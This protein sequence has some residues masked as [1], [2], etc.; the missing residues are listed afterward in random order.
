MANHRLL[1]REVGRRMDLY[2]RCRWPDLPS[3]ADRALRSA[4]RHTLERFEPD[5]II[6]A[7]THI[8]GN[9]DPSSDLDIHVI[10]A[11]PQRQRIQKWF[12]GV[13]AEI[14]VNPPAAIRRYFA[15]EV[16][17]PSTAHMLST[18][19]V[20]LDEAP[21]VQQLAL[22][23]REWLARPLELTETQLTAVR[24]FAA[25]AFDNAQDVRDSD[26]AAALRILNSAVDDML[27]YAFLARGKTLPRAKAYVAELRE[28]DTALAQLAHRYY[29][30][31]DVAEN[32]SLAEQIAALTV[33]E[34]GFFEWES[35]LEAVK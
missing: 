10:H 15:D 2:V 27:D 35:L 6:V 21:I 5:G 1:P 30:A 19:F 17:R 4:V 12:E 13:P 9:P 16:R 8:S 7:G 28:V 29:L 18:G 20:V 34:T 31:H 23:A 22:E 33:G 11:A 26:P 3:Q 24:Y 14:F 32:F 25:D